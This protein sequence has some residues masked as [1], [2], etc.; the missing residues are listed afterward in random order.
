[1]GFAVAELQRQSLVARSPLAGWLSPVTV[2][3][4]HSFGGGQVFV[5][6]AASPSDLSSVV[7]IVALA[8]GTKFSHSLLSVSALL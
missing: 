1:M 4:G 7:G 2:L 6:L 3:A 5:T 8:P